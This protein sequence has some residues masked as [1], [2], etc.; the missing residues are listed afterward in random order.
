MITM[1]HLDNGIEAQVILS[2]GVVA[3]V[4]YAGTEANAMAFACLDAIDAGYIDAGK[5]HLRT[6]CP[7]DPATKRLCG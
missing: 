6:C 5:G 1:K 2:N 4:G 7:N 3:G